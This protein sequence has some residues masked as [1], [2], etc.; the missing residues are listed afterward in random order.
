M[1]V[2]LVTYATHEGYTFRSALCARC[3]ADVY[4]DG[5]SVRQVAD[6]HEDDDAI[7]EG[8]ENC[9][10]WRDPRLKAADREEDR[11]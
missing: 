7:L 4:L 1:S 8:C 9:G 11:P 3:E 2:R 5:C 10:A 6:L